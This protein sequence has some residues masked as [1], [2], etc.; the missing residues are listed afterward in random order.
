M[1]YSLSVLSTALVCNLKLWNIPLG[2]DKKLSRIHLFVRTVYLNTIIDGVA[3]FV[4]LNQVQKMD[5]DFK[6]FYIIVDVAHAKIL[7]SRNEAAGVIVFDFQI[8]GYL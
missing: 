3:V 4:H 2:A 1:Y 5:L 7:F 6:E 8:K